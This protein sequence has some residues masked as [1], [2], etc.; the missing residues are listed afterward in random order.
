MAAVPD[1]PGSRSRVRGNRDRA[2]RDGLWSGR[3]ATGTDRE[4]VLWAG[5]SDWADADLIDNKS[6]LKEAV[7]K[8]I[9]YTAAIATIIMSLLNL[10]FALDDGGMGLAVAYAVVKPAKTPRLS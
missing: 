1:V 5:D 7:M 8:T 6:R 10:P 9:R 2:G 4:A 3:E